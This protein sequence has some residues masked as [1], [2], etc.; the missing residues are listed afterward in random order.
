MVEFVDSLNRD[1]EIRFVV[2]TRML[3]NASRRAVNNPQTYKNFHEFVGNLTKCTDEKISKNLVDF[4]SKAMTL[5]HRGWVFQSE[6][7]IVETDA[8]FTF[9]VESRD[10]IH[11]LQ[12]AIEVVNR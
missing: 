8:Y 3:D 1:V 12:V 6:C 9:A 11:L 2:R 5:T 4:F 7:D 10:R